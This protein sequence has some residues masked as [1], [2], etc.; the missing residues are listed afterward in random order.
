MKSKAL[1]WIGGIVYVLLLAAIYYSSFTHLV[2]SW[3]GDY[4]YAY[5]IPVVV[6]YLLVGEA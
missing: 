5:L 6:L 1:F 2:S 3:G 4:S